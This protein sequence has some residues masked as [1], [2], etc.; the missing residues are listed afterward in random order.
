MHRIAAF[1]LRRRQARALQNGQQEV[2]APEEMTSQ[3]DAIRGD[4]AIVIPDSEEQDGAVCWETHHHDE[5]SASEQEAGPSDEQVESESLRDVETRNKA[6][7]AK[8]CS[9]GTQMDV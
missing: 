6:K 9:N 7:S 8:S 1:N 5:Q 3:E 2:A 4:K